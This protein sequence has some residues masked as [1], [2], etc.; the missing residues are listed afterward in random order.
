MAIST[1]VHSCLCVF[2]GS[3]VVNYPYDDDPE[4]ISRY[5]GSPDD[6]TFKMVALA[7][8]RVSTSYSWIYSPFPSII[9]NL[10]TRCLD[11]LGTKDFSYVLGKSTDA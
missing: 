9:I 1:H 11:K 7:Y 2:L 4:G 10:L 6:A 5:S 8:S 3:L